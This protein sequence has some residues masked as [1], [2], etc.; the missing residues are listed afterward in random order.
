MKV[1]VIH[2]IYNRCALARRGLDSLCRQ[3]LPVQDF[4]VIYV[5]DGSTED[6]RE[7]VFKKFMGRVNI[8]HVKIDHTRHRIYKE[9][10][11]GGGHANWYHTPSLA[12]NVGIGLAR[13]EVLCLAHPEMIQR[14][15]NLEMGYRVCRESRTFAFGK[16][17]NAAPFLRAYFDEREEILLDLGFEELIRHIETSFGAI[18]FFHPG[19]Y[20]WYISFLAREG[21]AAVRGVDV[22]YMRGWAGEDDDFRERVKVAGWEPRDVWE[23]QAIH[24]NHEFEQVIG[25]PGNEHRCRSDVRAE[26][27]LAHNRARYKRFMNMS[28]QERL[29]HMDSVNRAE[30][31]T[32]EETIVSVD[33]YDGGGK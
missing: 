3:T 27:G 11:P 30:P 29:L 7:Q 16:C 24:Q 17:F 8:V 26:R 20:Y 6:L 31:W 33:R 13:G 4:E 21:A 2:P 9:Q 28:R 10:N 19:A 15:K 25:S 18:Q 32:G 12:M 1:S 23:I 14:E 22:E 5:D